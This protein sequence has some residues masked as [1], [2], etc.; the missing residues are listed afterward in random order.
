MKVRKIRAD[1]YKRA[2]Q[3]CS[4][5]FEYSLENERLCPSEYLC[6]VQ[7]NPQSRQ[8]I[9]WDSQW[10]AFA[11]DD[12]TMLSTFTAI[13][14]QANFD[15]HSVGMMGIGGVATLPEY[16][17]MGGIRA[18]FEHALPDFY[19]HGMVLSYLYPFSTVFYRKFGYEL[20]CNRMLHKIALNAV[21]PVEIKGSFHLLEP[22][23][24]LLGDIRRVSEAMQKQYNLMIL[25]EDIEYSWVKKADP[26]QDRVYTYVYRDE[27]GAPKGVVTYKPVIDQ[28]DRALDCSQR[29]WFADIEG[30]TALLHL[31]SR[32]KADHS[33]ALIHLPENVHL[34]AVIPEW[35]FGNVKRD[36]QRFGMVRVVNVEQ[37]L[38]LAQMRGK[39]ELTIDV[40]DEQIAQNNARFTVSFE[41][42]KPNRVSRTKNAPDLCLSI[43]DFSRLIC[44]AFH[45]NDLQWLPNVRI[46]C[47][48]EKLSKV[49]YRK[50]MFIN[51]YF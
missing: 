15:G 36:N 41:P 37:A 10:A 28:G 32:L 24:D 12:R 16:R 14:Y 8:D 6:Q 42:G 46:H 3:F 1:E 11:D 49:F 43:Q 19:E 34:D 45:A 44:G 25:Q 30:L 27:Q 38:S 39:D 47:S 17:R 23:A 35:S 31:L 33:H 9:H 51:R 21:S 50:P 29:F 13:P 20:G 5:A 26:F 7:S 40:H 22:G 48:V 18:C 2:Q 4:L